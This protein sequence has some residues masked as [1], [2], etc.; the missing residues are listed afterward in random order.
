MSAVTSTPMSP[1]AVSKI[2]KA[3]PTPLNALVPKHLHSKPV[4]VYRSSLP[5]PRREYDMLIPH[6]PPALVRGSLR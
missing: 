2:P 3:P 5:V 4:A 6:S 1:T